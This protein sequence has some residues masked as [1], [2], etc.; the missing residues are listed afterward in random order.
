M[1][2]LCDAMKWSHLP[3]AGGLY[4]QDP[5]LMDCFKKI[6]AARNK[7][8]AEQQKKQEQQMKASSNKSSRSPARPARARRR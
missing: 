3:R 2:A 5:E 6:F 7:H 8:Q 4:D 1:F